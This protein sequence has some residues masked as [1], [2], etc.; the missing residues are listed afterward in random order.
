MKAK[1]KKWAAESLVS[2]TEKKAIPTPKQQREAGEITL[3]MVSAAMSPVKNKKVDAVVNKIISKVVSKIK[4]KV[5]VIPPKKVKPKRVAPPKPKPKAG[6]QGRMQG[7]TVKQPKPSPIRVINP[8]LS[9]I[10]E[11]STGQAP[12]KEQAHK[13]WEDIYTRLLKKSDKKL[14]SNRSTKDI[15]AENESWQR[16]KKSEK[17]ERDI[18]AQRLRDSRKQKE[19]KKPKKAKGGYVKKYAKGGGVRAARF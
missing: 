2:E 7:T 3:G 11:E 12:K 5:K 9:S 18:E 19:V 13:E 8:E 17:K 6:F 16:Q 14:S 10:T 15:K 1:S 4:P